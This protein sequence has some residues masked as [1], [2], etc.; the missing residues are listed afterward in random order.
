MSDDAKNDAKPRPERAPPPHKCP[1]Y[2]LDLETTGL[3]P[4]RHEILEVGIVALNGATAVDRK[5]LPR[6][7][8]D[9]DPKA[10]EVNGYDP[11]VWAD[12]GWELER[13][14]EFVS[15]TLHHA[16]I[17]GW[18]VDFDIGF[19][20]EAG[21]DSYLHRHRIVD[22]KTLAWEHLARHGYVGSLSLKAS[23]DFLGISNQGAHTAAADAWRTR[24]VYLELVQ[25][26]FADR[27]AWRVKHWL[28]RGR[29]R[30]H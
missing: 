11:K 28:K 16:V 14:M 6:R 23:C 20:R 1:V 8:E 13:A 10:L 27:I 17:I 24:A 3:D 9:A 25:A 29:R 2:F 5:V 18:N 12:E 30:G 26:R 4:K 22:A 21:L 15:K 7:I 19:L